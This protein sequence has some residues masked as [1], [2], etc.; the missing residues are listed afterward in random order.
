LKR[1]VAILMV[2]IGVALVGSAAYLGL[3]SAPSILHADVTLGGSVLSAVGSPTR[4][5]F[6]AGPGETYSTPTTTG[7]CADMG[8]F[9][10]CLSDTYLYS[11]QLPNNMQYTVIVFDSLGS[12]C[13]AG[14]MHVT[15]GNATA[16]VS[17]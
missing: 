16:N 12:S 4:V 1:R 10:D 9:G 8:F 14:V 7:G 3:N 17:C 2:L 15:G 5:E 6:S 13:D 11:I